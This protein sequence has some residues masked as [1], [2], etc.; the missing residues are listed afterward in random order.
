MFSYLREFNKSS[1]FVFKTFCFSL[2]SSKQRNT[3]GGW[4]IS[5]LF[6][7]SLK[8]KQSIVKAKMLNKFRWNQ[9][10]DSATPRN[11]KGLMQVVD[12]T[13]LM[14]VCHQ[15][16]SSVLAW[17]RT[18]HQVCE[19]QLSKQLASSLWIKSLDNELATSL[20]T[21]CRRLVIIKP[22]QA[23][24]THPDIGLMTARQQ[25]CNRFAATS[26]FLVVYITKP[27]S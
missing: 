25:P 16:V 26:A 17:S 11:D 24:R 7:K 8:R 20:L 12:F 9:C 23:M 22:E 10:W 4:R 18:L 13:G 6:I 21:S 2:I 3:L 19:N 1:R 5:V 27:C 15:V 14:K